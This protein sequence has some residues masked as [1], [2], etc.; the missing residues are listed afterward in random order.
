MTRSP[1]LD[2]RQQDCWDRYINPTSE[3]FANAKQSAI[4]AGFS[5]SHAEDIKK[6]DW[7]VGKERRLRMRNKGERKLEA[8][9][10]MPINVLEFIDR[11]GK[12]IPYVVTDSTLLR[13][14]QDTAKFAVERLGKED[15]SSRQEV[16]GAGGGPVVDPM[17]KEKG[18][19]AIQDFLAKGDKAI[20]ELVQ[21]HNSK[22]LG[23]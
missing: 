10:D 12:R 17:A 16:T 13:I 1:N 6:L 18:D 15:W 23:E 9:L 8:I 11:N 20:N 19:Q 4:A 22:N 5:E 3:T 7:W 2:P 21:S 14:Q